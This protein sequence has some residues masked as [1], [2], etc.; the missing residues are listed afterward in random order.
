MRLEPNSPVVIIQD[1]FRNGGTE[2]QSLRLAEALSSAGAKV[3]VLRFAKGGV[4]EQ[5]L[6]SLGVPVETLQPFPTPLPLWAPGLTRRLRSLRPGAIV[7]MGRTANC[8]AGRIKSMLPDVPV[9]G[10]LRTG[11]QI[12]PMQRNAWKRVDAMVVNCQWWRDELIRQG[13]D[14]EKINVCPNPLVWDLPQSDHLAAMR[15]TMRQSQVLSPATII[16]LQVA[17]FRRGKRHRMLI[18]EF[19]EA[20]AMRPEVDIRLWLV[21]D[22]FTRRECEKL[23]AHHPMGDRIWFA[24]YQSDPRPWYAAADI[25]VSCSREDAMPNFLIEAQAFGLPVVAMDCRGVRET[26]LEGETGFLVP[27]ADTI[28]FRHALVRAAEDEVWRRRAGTIAK[29]WAT[30]WFDAGR[31]SRQWVAVITNFLNSPAKDDSTKGT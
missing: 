2:R 26:F 10:S 11:K 16:L 1:Q 15:L 25:A 13:I 4:L 12:L 9:I 14:G 8:Y 27:D 29:E 18:R 3:V 24:G 28:G 20:A 30:A 19:L 23:T 7:C 31:R 17:G 21:G 5:N 6:H 22:G